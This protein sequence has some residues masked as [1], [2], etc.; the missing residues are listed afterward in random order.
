MVIGLLGFTITTQI[1]L[2]IIFRIINGV[3]FALSGTSQISLASRYIP[4]DK[5]GEGFGYLGL[6]MVL[7]SAVA[8]GLGL[9][10]ADNFGMKITFLISAGLL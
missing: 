4:K 6:G 1:P 10:I 3:G 5:M 7:G 8:P 2:L 9:A